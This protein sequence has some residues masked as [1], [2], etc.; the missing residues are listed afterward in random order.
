M[1]LHNPYLLQKPASAV[2]LVFIKYVISE[3][4]INES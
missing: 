3:A 4:F 1:Q 2:S